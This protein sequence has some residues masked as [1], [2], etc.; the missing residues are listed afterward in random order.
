MCIYVY[1]YRL[2]FARL[3]VCEGESKNVMSYYDTNGDGRLDLNEFVW[4]LLDIF[5]NAMPGLQVCV[6]TCTC[7]CIDVYVCNFRRVWICT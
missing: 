6:W 7:R 4:A 5:D 3:G 1:V 2:E